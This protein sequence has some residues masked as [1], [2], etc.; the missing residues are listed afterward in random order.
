MSH[1]VSLERNLYRCVEARRWRSCPS[2]FTFLRKPVNWLQC[3]VLLVAFALGSARADAQTNYRYL[4]PVADF[5]TA[6][7]A[8]WTAVTGC[9]LTFTPGSHVGQ[10]GGDCHGTSE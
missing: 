1:Y 8:T 4:A 3:L 5:T 7:G 6:S 10:L 2:L 9:S